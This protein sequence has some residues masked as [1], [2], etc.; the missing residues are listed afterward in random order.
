MARVDCIL[1]VSVSLSGFGTTVLTLCARCLS[2]VTGGVSS[3][4]AAAVDAAAVAAAAVAAVAAAAAAAADH[5]PWCT[6]GEVQCDIKRY[7]TFQNLQWSEGGQTRP[8]NRLHFPLPLWCIRCIRRTH[9]V[10]VK[11]GEAAAAFAGIKAAAAGKK[12]ARA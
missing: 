3:T 9:N 6:L 8:L 5:G 10:K 1:T 11:R 7:F 2:R 4:T 12:R